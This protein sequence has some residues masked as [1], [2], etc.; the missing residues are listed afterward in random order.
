MRKELNS[1]EKTVFQLFEKSRLTKHWPGLLYWDFERPQ[2]NGK[3][4]LVSKTLTIFSLSSNISV[5]HD[6]KWICSICSRLIFHKAIEL[7]PHIS[8][9]LGRI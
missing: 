5:H 3:M 4:G 6:L 7:N 9:L 2:K 8:V 1:S